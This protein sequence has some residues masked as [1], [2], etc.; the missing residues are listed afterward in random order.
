MPVK[1]RRRKVRQGG[2]LQADLE[3]HC[4]LGQSAWKT[5]HACQGQAKN[6]GVG[7]YRQKNFCML[8][9]VSTKNQAC[10]GQVKKV[11][12]DGLFQAELSHARTVGTTTKIEPVQI[13]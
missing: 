6:G 11:R 13:G 10:Q 2:A 8:R 3:E 7:C 5:S 4:M 9:T 12:Q 1:V